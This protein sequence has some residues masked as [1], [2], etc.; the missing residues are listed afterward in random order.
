M[1][2]RSSK[3]V[4]THVVLSLGNGHCIENYVQALGRGTFNG[5]ESV[6][7]ANN[8]QHVTVLTHKDDLKMAR[9]YINFLDEIHK[10]LHQGETVEGALTGATGKFPDSANFLRHATKRRIGQRKNLKAHLDGDE[11]FEEAE[12]S[13]DDDID[14]S[15]EDSFVGELAKKERY[16]EDTVAQRVLKSVV[17]LKEEDRKFECTKKQILEKFNDTYQDDNFRMSNDVILKI[18]DAYE[19]D[20]VLEKLEVGVCPRWT[21]V[22]WDEV[23]Y[24]I[25][26]K[27]VG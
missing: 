4:P 23:K 1:S 21:A 2:I 24:L 12:D 10:R 17:D 25:N 18:L 16:W 7:K 20:S 8:H 5:V 15:D 3:R 26:D 22:N 19:A 13:D 11:L 9:K 27:L 14:V 6:L